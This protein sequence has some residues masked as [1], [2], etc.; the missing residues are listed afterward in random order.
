MT[1]QFGQTSDYWNHKVKAFLHDPPD[2]AIHIPGHEERSNRLL[3]A[4]GIQATLDPGEYKRADIVASGMDRTPLPGYSTAKEQNGAIDFCKQ[5]A[6]THPTGTDGALHLIGLL[7]DEESRKSLVQEV[8]AAM[9]EL[10]KEDLGRCTDGRGLS[11]NP[12]YKG[13]EEAFAPARFHYLFFLLR[14]RLAERNIGGL[15]GLWY[16]MPADT[17]IPDHSIWQHSGLVSALASC[18]SLSDQNEASLMVFAVTPVQDFIGRARKLRDFW[19]GSLLLSWLAFEGIRA[20]IYQLGADHILYPS[21]HG[22]PLVDQMI[23]N[24]WE[25]DAYLGPK[26]GSAGV[27]SFPNK[28]V[29]LVPTGMEEEIAGQIQDS[30][31]RQWLDLGAA[32]RRQVEKWVGE[33]DEITRQ[34]DRQLTAY[35]EFAWAASP[36]VRKKDKDLVEELLPKNTISELFQFLK[37]SETLLQ[38]KNIRSGDG[39]GILYSVSHRLAQTMLAAGKSHRTDRRQEEPGIKCDMFGEFEILHFP[40]KKGDDKNPPPSQDPFWSAFKEKWNP[41]SD[42]GASERL[43]AIG[44]VKRIAYRV[45]QDMDNHPL[46]TMFEKGPTF[47][48]TTEMA[49]TDWFGRLESKAGHEPDLAA[50]LAEF[51]DDRRRQLLA[52]WFHQIN[53]P[54]QVRRFGREIADT[55][56]NQRR[57]AK[58]IF[59]KHLK[60]EDIHKYYALLMMD[61]DCMGKLVNGETLGATWRSVL[62]PD[63]VARL[64]GSFDN[65]YKAFWQNYLAEK[66]LISPA[67]HAAIS[68]ALADFSLL[69]VPE[70]VKRYGGQLI[71]AGGDDVCAILP[72][73][74]ALDAAREIAATYGRGFIHAEAGRTGFPEGSWKPHPGKLAIYL[75]AGKGISISAGIIIAHHKKPL[76]RVIERAHQLLDMAKKK[77]GRNGFCLELDKR[78]GGGR[79][80]MSRWDAVSSGGTIVE[81]FIETAK[82]L[83]SSGEAPMSASLAYR[84]AT[85][86]DGILPL[87]TREEQLQRFVKKQLDRSGLA[88]GLT[89]EERDEQLGRIASHVAALLAHGSRG[90]NPDTL[91]AESLIIANFLGHCMHERNSIVNAQQG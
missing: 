32:T 33:H 46:K 52:Q 20:V 4:L 74:T 28:F 62:H 2:K 45:C 16:R 63:L 54:E 12:L 87:L 47:P 13:N 77:G 76:G 35:W 53:E 44:L 59:T 24:D 69:T 26:M 43:C 14:R 68:E 75:G 6:I 30:I 83:E 39:Q 58:K 89:E 81:H 25:M 31:Q 84:L 40:F 51:P 49:L 5:P 41:K 73:S 36:L 57:A 17:R 22:Q 18:Y 29:C 3:D 85:F 8:S 91:E 42:F 55:E 11:E 27:A 71:Y 7:S 65:D 48:S 79:I 72:A 64:Q 34:F 56:E 82:A 88:A 90:R 66:R 86:G 67:V 78:S 15:G 10:V 19:A 37:D 70:V 38:K 23:G 60:V 1:M 50:E 21:L 61:G 9:Q 80:F